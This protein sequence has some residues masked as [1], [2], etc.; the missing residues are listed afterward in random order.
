MKRV[1][2]M[3][4]TIALIG[5]WYGPV[6]GAVKGDIPPAGQCFSLMVGSTERACDIATNA[7][8]K[9]LISWQFHGGINQRFVLQET[10]TPGAY[11]IVGNL[12]GLSLGEGKD[13][14]VSVTRDNRVIGR[15]WRFVPVQG[16]YRVV[17]AASGKALTCVDNQ[18]F[19]LRDVDPNQT[20]TFS[21]RIIHSSADLI[22]RKR[23][24]M[25]DVPI[26][27]VHTHIMGLDR[28]A[29]FVAIGAIL[30]KNYDTRID[31]WITLDGNFGAGWNQSYP[32]ESRKRF[33]ERFQ[34]VLQTAYTDILTHKP[35]DITLLAGRGD[36]VGYKMWWGY[37]KGIDDPANEPTYA[38]MA[39]IGLPVASA[40]VAQPF[41]N[42]EFPEE[43][44]TE[45]MDR[46]EHVLKKH[47]KLVV[48][49]AHMGCMFID[50]TRLQRLERMLKSYP[51]LHI[52]TCFG[53]SH[54]VLSNPDRLRAFMIKYSDRILF[55]SDL[56][57]RAGNL[58]PPNKFEAMAA[59]YDNNFYF[60]ES[61]GYITGA[62]FSW[63]GTNCAYRCLNLPK[64]VLEKIYYK[65][66]LRIYPGLRKSLKAVRK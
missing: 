20:Q 11:R 31:I 12:E 45:A 59:E 35:D 47:P 28:N 66:A 10:V 61:D 23:P 4:L 24:N 57:S 43:R 60:F 40:H 53:F 13:G 58:T 8:G 25:A 22:A 29:D 49:M 50:E 14:K 9:N 55:G 16:G 48:V 7:S 51:N 37:Q 42:K 26:I 27:D 15:T 52:D 6:S 64:N 1:I 17:Y 62:T 44:W 63:G 2:M 3:I 54:F 32:S 21:F 65:N 41:F 46:W 5:V 36:V 30:E 19:A 33:G 39:E 18:W 38:R 34:Y 56:T